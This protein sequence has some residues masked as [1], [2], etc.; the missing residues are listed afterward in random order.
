MVLHVVGD[1]SLHV[2]KLYEASGLHAICYYT[3]NITGLPKQK[4]GGRG[5]PYTFFFFPFCTCFACFL[6]LML[7]SA[8]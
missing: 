6:S 8:V 7:D 2:G 1:I 4:K 3:Y 5:L